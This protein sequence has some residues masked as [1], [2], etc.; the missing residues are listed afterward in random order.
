MDPLSRKASFSSDY[1]KQCTD[2]IYEFFYENNMENSNEISY[3][4]TEPILMKFH[5]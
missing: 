4:T 3:E 1:E 2:Y 5:S